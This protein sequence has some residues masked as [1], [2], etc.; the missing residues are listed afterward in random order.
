MVVEVVGIIGV[1]RDDV[2]WFHDSEDKLFNAR[3]SPR[4]L[5]FRSPTH[6]LPVKI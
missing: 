3:S 4:G 2:Q 1:L 5:H 6:R